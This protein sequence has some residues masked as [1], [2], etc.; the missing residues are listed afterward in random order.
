MNDHNQIP[1][2]SGNDFIPL[3]PFYVY[4]LIDP[5]DASVFYVGKGQGNRVLNHV[6]EAKFLLSR[7]QAP[8]REKHQRIHD[9]FKADK[10]PIELIVGRYESE[11]EAFA[12]ESTLINFVYDFSQLT[13]L[14]RGHGA[15]CIRTNGCFERIEGID[16]PKP[17]RVNDG[18]FRN[19]K[20][21]GASCYYASK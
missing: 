17:V 13:N 12:V 15:E 14:N 2:A 21:A 19:A 18:S 5:R 11:Q 9:I 8:E 10:E 7:T 3:L 20:V 16:L 4:V 6:A 1:S